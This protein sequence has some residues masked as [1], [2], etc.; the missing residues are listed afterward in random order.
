MALA[1]EHRAG[2]LS[3]TPNQ[4]RLYMWYVTCQ[5]TL[6]CLYLHLRDLS[7]RQTRAFQLALSPTQ[8]LYEDK[9]GDDLLRLGDLDRLKRMQSKEMETT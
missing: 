6:E 7:K 4:A 5:I 8:L 9:H 3:H 2:I 1:T